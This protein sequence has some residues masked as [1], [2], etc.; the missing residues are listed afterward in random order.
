VNGIKPTDDFSS[1]YASLLEGSY[2]CVD[3]I[4]INAF[5]P[6]GQTG[7]GL[8][9]WWRDW[10][11]SEKTL[12]DA[13][14]KAVAGDFAR[15]LKGWCQKHRIPFVD[16]RANEE[17]HALAESLLPK[18]RKFRGIFAVLVGRAPAPVWQVQFN[19]Q[20]QIINVR[21]RDPWPH[22]QHYYFQIIDP[23]WGHI[24]V[25]MCGYPPFWR[26]GGA[27]WP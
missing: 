19:H 24:M 14:L 23:E 8:R 15:R 17:K 6:M 3:R 9:L 7:G 22:V 21:H 1:Y 18:D 2:D 10:K 25:R 4:T 20:G 5:Y 13:G 27:Q 12:S 16:C 26:A 11:G